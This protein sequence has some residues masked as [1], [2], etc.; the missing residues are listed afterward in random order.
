MGVIS[1]Y[2]VILGAV[3]Y[4]FYR[5]FI[6]FAVLLTGIPI[7]L[8]LYKKKL[9]R[10]TK[11][12]LKEEFADCL[13]SVCANVKA[14]YS[15]ENAFLES[16]KDLKLFYGEKSL[17]AA[18]I[19]A[20]EQGLKLN[21]TLESRLSDLGERSGVDD[22]LV[23]SK[24]FETAKRNGG[25][26]KEVL[27]ATSETIRANLETEKQIRVTIA[28]KRLEL[29]IMEVI[30][31][32]IMGY[33]ELTTRGYFNVLYHNVRGVLFMTVCLIVYGTSAYIGTGLMRIDV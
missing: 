33:I 30:P 21:R 24:V 22:I 19:K 27:E 15:A 31:F 14:G 20:M 11:Q 6:F 3:S 2:L 13:D 8:K 25:N 28:Q 7:C 29:I 10:Q 5:S 12:R 26:L 16:L 4:F 32:F 23:F 1:V 9:I 18:E 17:M